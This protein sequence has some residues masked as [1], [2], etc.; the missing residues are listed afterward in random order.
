MARMNVRHRPLQV[1]NLVARHSSGP[2]RW[3]EADRAVAER[4]VVLKRVLQ[5]Y[6]FASIAPSNLQ[7]RQPLGHWACSHPWPGDPREGH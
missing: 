3:H 7:Q 2:I 4:A 6:L 1:T 5:R